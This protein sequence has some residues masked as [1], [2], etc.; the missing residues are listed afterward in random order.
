MFFNFKAHA[1]ILAIRCKFSSV[2]Q[3]KDTYSEV[4]F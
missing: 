1:G 2:L 4:Q 3:Q